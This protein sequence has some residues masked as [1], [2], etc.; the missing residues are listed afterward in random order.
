MVS[1]RGVSRTRIHINFLI[2]LFLI[3]KIYLGKI[4]N[5][6]SLSSLWLHISPLFLIFFVLLIVS[7]FLESI[8]SRK[9]D[10]DTSFF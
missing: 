5:F 9:R 4:L 2:Y 1:S 10:R 7:S 3:L 8:L 6:G